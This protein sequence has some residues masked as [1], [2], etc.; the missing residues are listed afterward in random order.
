MKTNHALKR[1]AYCGS[2]RTMKEISIDE[3]QA[4]LDAVCDRALAGEVIRL[5]NRAG[6]LVELTPVARGRNRPRL[7][8][9]A[10]ADDEEDAEWAAFENQCAKASA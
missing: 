5:R 3:A 8:G 7:D 6:A 2:V 9:H 10:L 4:Q 1:A